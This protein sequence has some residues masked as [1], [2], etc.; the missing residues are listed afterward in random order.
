M[1]R[2]LS[3]MRINAQQGHYP[4]VAQLSA[5]YSTMATGPYDT[6][7]WRTLHW[8]CQH[9][10]GVLDACC[11]CRGTGMVSGKPKP[12]CPACGAMV[13]GCKCRV[14]WK[15]PR[16]FARVPC[17][18]CDGAGK[19]RVHVPEHGELPANMTARQAELT[20]NGATNAIMQQ[21]ADAIRAL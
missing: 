21:V 18:V 9:A 10:V 13:G 15:V 1:Q 17:E 11:A 20:R 8:L 6:E 4:T 19:L 7:C 12:E 14:G 2:R 16:G 5:T 3:L